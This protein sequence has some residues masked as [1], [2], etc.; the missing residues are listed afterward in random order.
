M[1]H[2]KSQCQK[3]AE[4]LLDEFSAKVFDKLNKHFT[5]MTRKKCAYPEIY[6]VPGNKFE[7][8]FDFFTNRPLVQ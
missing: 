7:D 3:C 8:I 1:K 2:S 5:I 6:K 4:N